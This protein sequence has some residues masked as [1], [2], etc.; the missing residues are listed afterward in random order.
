M[1]FSISLSRYPEFTAIIIFFHLTHNT[2]IMKNNHLRVRS[3]DGHRRA[4][5]SHTGH[6][7]CPFIVEQHFL[8]INF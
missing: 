8:I 3:E 4:A 7:K 6:H 1:M 5:S 2:Q